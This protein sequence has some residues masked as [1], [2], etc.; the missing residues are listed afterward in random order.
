MSQKII[1]V[2]QIC[3]SAAAVEDEH[4]ARKDE[5]AAHSRDDSPR[6]VIRGETL[7]EEVE[8]QSAIAHIDW[9]S[10]TVMCPFKVNELDWVTPFIETLVFIPRSEWRFVGYGWQ[11]YRER[12]DLGDCGLLAF[13]GERQHG[14]VHVSL[15]A[16]GCARI[17]D[18]A[19]VRIFGETYE[20]RITRIDLAHDDLDGVTLSVERALQWRLEGGFDLN[21]RPAK[22]RYIDDFDSGDGKTLYIGKRKNGKLCRVY[23][24]GRQLGGGQPNSWCR[25]EVELRRKGRVIPWDVLTKPGNYLAGAY[26]CLAYL[27]LEQCKLKTTQKQFEITYDHMVRNL[28]NAAGRGLNV[29]LQVHQG[30][31][32]GVLADLVREGRPKRLASI[33]SPKK[34]S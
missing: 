30:D 4:G 28:R 10:F 20:A 13:G 9:L 33:P 23:E 21:G 6:V 31:S 2:E 27:T 16:M 22:G 26:P 5:H 11:G 29:M 8:T 24:K 12:I 19:A 25:A 32:G 14:T 15:N 3:P 7:I 34:K 17:A 1:V 18:W